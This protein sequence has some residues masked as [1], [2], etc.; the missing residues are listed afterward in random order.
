MDELKQACE[1]YIAYIEG[2]EYHED[3]TDD[4][5]NAVFEAALELVFGAGIWDRINAAIR[6]HEASDG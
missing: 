3:G 6:A 2:K 5:E 4:Y 1:E